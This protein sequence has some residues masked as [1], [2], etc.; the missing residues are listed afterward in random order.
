MLGGP[1]SGKGTQCARL[2]KEYRFKHFSM[3][4]ILREEQNRPG[5]DIADSIRHYIEEGLTISKDVTVRLLEEAMT[6]VIDENGTRKFLIDG[7]PRRPDQAFTFEDRVVRSRFT[8]FLKC[9]ENIMR[10]RLLN[11]RKRTDRSD[12]NEESIKKRFKTFIE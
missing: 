10:E 3:G 1:G 4:D 11:R 9:T 12:D 8:L 7:F 6:A 2:A 5:S